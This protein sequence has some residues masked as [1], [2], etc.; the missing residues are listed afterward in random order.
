M[1]KKILVSVFL[2]VSVFLYRTNSFAVDCPEMPDQINKAWEADVEAAVVKIGS[3]RGDELRS[4]T[5]AAAL[6]LLGKLPND[7]KAYLEQMMLSSYCT[8][9]LNEKTMMESEKIKLMEEYI[10]EVRRAIAGSS[11]NTVA[12]SAPVIKFQ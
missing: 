4:R 1:G 2:M 12:P 3:V 6:A 11:K 7:A 8:I 10:T 9:L 5:N